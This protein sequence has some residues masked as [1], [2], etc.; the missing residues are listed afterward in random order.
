MYKD[1]TDCEKQQLK[2]EL[3]AKVDKI[4]RDTLDEMAQYIITERGAT[5]SEAKWKAFQ[6]MLCGIT[7]DSEEFHKAVEEMIT[8]SDMF[9]PFIKE[10]TKED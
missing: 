6:L 10:N 4:L 3:Q 5:E 7:P 9:E 8:L 1:L 2:K